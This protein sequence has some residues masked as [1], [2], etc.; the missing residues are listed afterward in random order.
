[1]DDKESCCRKP[2]CRLGAGQSTAALTR[3]DIV[4]YLT[5]AILPPHNIPWG[6]QLNRES[7]TTADTATNRHYAAAH[8]RLAYLLLSYFK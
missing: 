6:F 7:Q 4:D 2:R 8:T 3:C 1:M 5:W